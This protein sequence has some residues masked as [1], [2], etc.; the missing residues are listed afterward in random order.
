MYPQFVKNCKADLSK[1]VL[2]GFFGRGQSHV[3]S[4][5]QVCLTSTSDK[6]SK[7]S[8]LLQGGEDSVSFDIKY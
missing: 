3:L 4:A 7:I 5:V 8:S 6:S 2:T 1:I